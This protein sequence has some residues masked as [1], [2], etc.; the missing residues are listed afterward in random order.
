MHNPK[1]RDFGKWF[2]HV[3]RWECK[4]NAVVA[5]LEIAC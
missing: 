4:L 1:V 3:Q 5:V 2:S